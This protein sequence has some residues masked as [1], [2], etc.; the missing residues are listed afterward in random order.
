[1]PGG[2]VGPP[3]RW[4]AT[5]NVE[6]GSEMEEGTRGPLARVGGLSLDKLF[7]WVPEFLVTPLLETMPWPVRRASP[8]LGAM[9]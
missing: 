2:P 5:S 7:A 1:L 6:G 4:A 3:A 8:P 9:I